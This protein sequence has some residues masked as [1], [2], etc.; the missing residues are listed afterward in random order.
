MHKLIILIPPPEDMLLFED[1]WPMFLKQAER[2]PGLIKEATI[3]IE[4]TFY[5]DFEISMMHELH[6]ESLEALQTA[7]ASPVGQA[8]GQILQ[9]ITLGNMT[10]LAADHRE[11]DIENIRKY[12]KNEDADT[13]N[14]AP[15]SYE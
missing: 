5:G 7:M 8:A 11:D 6:F 15:D 1:S 10:L 9:K 4:N 3:R 14:Q 13:D 12:Q 2:M